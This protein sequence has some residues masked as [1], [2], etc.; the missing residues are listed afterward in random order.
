MKT[1]ES[2]FWFVVRNYPSIVREGL[3][4][5][6]DGPAVPE[7]RVDPDGER[8]RDARVRFRR[9]FHIG[10]PETARPD[11]APKAAP[12]T[13]TL[14]LQWLDRSR[15]EPVWRDTEI[16]IDLATRRLARIEGWLI[17]RSRMGSGA[18]GVFIF[19]S[20]ALAALSPYIVAYNAFWRARE[21]KEGMSRHAVVLMERLKDR[22][23]PAT[24]A[25]LR[26]ALRNEWTHHRKMTRRVSRE[27]ARAAL[28]ECEMTVSRFGRPDR[29]P[30]GE[31]RS[32]RDADGDVIADY[33]R[34]DADPNPVTL[35]VLGSRLR[36]ADAEALL[37]VCLHRT[38]DTE[39]PET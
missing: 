12:R 23:D 24:E 29:R 7:L 11:P 33:E 39:S 27:E 32:W 36:G 15:E 8:K 5:T 28:T 17:G 13:R 19:A 1:D 18:L 3:R 37:D 6:T 20:P 10:D 2:G 30:C 4:L 31:V 26:E 21:R 34:E 25:L 14:H 35:R 16:E 9:P 38:D 22:L